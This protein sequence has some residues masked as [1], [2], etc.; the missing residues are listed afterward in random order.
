[1]INRPLLFDASS[2]FT[3]V[4]ELRGEAPDLFREGSTVSLAYYEIGNA[5]WRECFLLRRIAP[6]EAS[7]LLI[8][9]F[10]MLRTM[11]VAAL[12][13]EDLGNA[14]LD[15]AGRL[16]ITYYDAAY[17]TEAQ[18]TNKALVTDDEKLAEAAERIGIKTL[19]SKTIGH[20]S[21]P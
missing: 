21:R 19:T 17:L 10:A 3:L 12:E 1:M 11:E 9:L 15:L 14:I 18:R 6:E 7:Q 4:R 8:S 16:N 2:V 20:Q 13:D 5:L